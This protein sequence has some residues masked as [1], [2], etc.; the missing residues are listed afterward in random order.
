MPFNKLDDSAAGK[1]RPRF[2]LQTPLD[3]DSIMDIIA[4]HSQE[5]PDVHC[6]RHARVLRLSIPK[7]D[8]HIWSPVL[9]LSF[10]SE[11]DHTIIR[12]MIG[13]SESIWQTI[14]VFY[15][16][17]SILGFFGSMYAL[18]E[19]QLHDNLMWLSIIPLT[20]LALSSIFAISASGKKQAHAQMLHLLR[21]LRRSVDQVACTR[22]EE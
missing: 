12:G 2:K 20:L 1:I 21:F 19:W 9:H 22:V 11:G 5:T 16:S 3:I 17:I 14:M 18:A 13:P 8:Q 7:D 6:R 4:G 15:L 10:D